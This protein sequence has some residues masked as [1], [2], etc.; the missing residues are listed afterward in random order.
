MRT[1]LSDRI[2]P[3]VEAAPWVVDEVKRL[4]KELAAARSKAIRFDLD[5]AGIESRARN[6]VALVKARAEVERLRWLAE[7]GCENTPTK[8]CEC[9]GCCTARERAERGEA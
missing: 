1:K 3:N 2:R 8:G 9:P 6:E 5:Q 7:A 4:E